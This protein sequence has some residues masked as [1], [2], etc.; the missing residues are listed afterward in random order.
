MA[1]PPKEKGNLGFM[2]FEMGCEDF[3]FLG[4]GFWIEG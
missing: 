4:F 2:D 1:E 3:W